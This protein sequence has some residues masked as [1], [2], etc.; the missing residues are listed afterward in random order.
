MKISLDGLWSLYWRQQQPTEETALPDFSK[1]PC[2]KAKVPGNVELDLQAAGKLPDLYFGNNIWQAK[3]YST[4]EWWY[5][6]TFKVTSDFLNQT[7]DLVFAGLDCIADITLNGRLL[8][9]CANMLIEHRFDV[10]E[11]LVKGENEIIVHI[12]SAL[13][14]G[15]KH[16]ADPCEW[17]QPPNWPGQTVRKAPHMFGWDIMPRLIS[18]GLFRRVS[19]ESCST[20]KILSAYYYCTETTRS[21]AAIGLKW[22]FTTESHDLSKFRLRLTLKCGKQK[23]VRTFNVYE[24]AGQFSMTIDNPRLWWPKGYGKPDLYKAD[25]E[26]L[27]NG[28]VIDRRTEKIGLRSLK[29][30]ST[31]VSSKNGE[32]SF[33]FYCNGEPIMIKGSNH[34]PLD[35]FHSRDHLRLIDAMKLYDDIGC[36]MIRCW[37]GNVYEDH[38]FYDF[39][40]SR[41]IMVWQD[42]AFACAFYPQT[43]EFQKVVAAEAEA[44][45]RKLRNHPS[46]A[47]WAGDNEVD[48]LMLMLEPGF[49]PERNRLTRQ[50]LPP[51]VARCDPFRSYLPSSPYCGPEVVKKGIEFAS[52]QH[53][54]GPRDYYKS[55]YY[56]QSNAC[57]ASEIGYHGCPSVRSMKQFISAGKLWPWENNDEWLTHA[58]NPLENNDLYKYRIKLMADQIHALFGFYPANLQDFVRASQIS[59]AEAVKYFIELFRSQKWNKSGLIWW[60]LLDGW[61]Q[62]SDAVVDYYFR[63]KLAY[64]YIKRVQTPV[65]IVIKDPSSWHCD[66]VVC[67]DTLNKT[68]GK[69]EIRDA[70]SGK[71][72]S[73][74]KFTA[75]KN[76]NAV[77][78]KIR[79][80]TGQQNMFLIR[81]SIGGKKFGNHYLFGTPPFDFKTYLKWIKQI[82]NLPPDFDAKDVF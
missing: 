45:I 30:V 48:V 70:D 34:V 43:D 23:H 69:Y 76:S 31:E 9:S 13:L 60:N 50:T 81:Y 25:F 62:F 20:E 67:N 41:G 75:E 12:K 37:G 59:Q 65:C 54:W 16:I 53:L 80:S 27:H 72:L 58:T 22:Q 14:E 40:D 56:S 74:G 18:A 64:H 21:R 77:V 52:E 10:S 17:T 71:V 63:K 55:P 39:C 79:V 44:V 33:V 28:R 5:V 68:G 32:G 24:T 8:G 2:V 82:E 61:P 1:L 11:Y 7:V 51:V 3:P 49:N 66:V 42:F 38:A 57:F 73:G 19:L 26:L 35:A 78:D 36:N 46:I 6:R 47:L 15:R 29:L 4:A